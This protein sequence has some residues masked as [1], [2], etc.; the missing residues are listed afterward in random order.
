[1]SAIEV[2]KNPSEDIIRPKESQKQRPKLPKEAT[3][4]PSPHY[5][6]KQVS[7]AQPKSGHRFWLARTHLKFHFAGLLST[8]LTIRQCQNFAIN[9]TL[10]A[11]QLVRDFET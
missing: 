7:V 8:Q 10:Y 5:R 9:T 6:A 4:W 2:S 3:F 1:L 11:L